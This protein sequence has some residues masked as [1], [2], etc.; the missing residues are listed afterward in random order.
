MTALR[1]SVRNTTLTAT[2]DYAPANALL[3]AA[4]F[5]ADGRLLGAK[6]VTLGG[7]S[8]HRHF[9]ADVNAAKCK[10]FLVDKASFV[11]LCAAVEAGRG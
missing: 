6:T 7:G 3:I 10:L 2:V 8:E 5:D 1:G 11:P 4:W 9:T